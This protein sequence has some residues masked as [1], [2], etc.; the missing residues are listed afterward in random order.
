MSDVDPSIPLAVRP[1]QIDNPMDVQA[2]GLQLKQLALQTQSAQQDYNDSQTLRSLYQKNSAGGTLDQ[3]GLLNDAYSAGLGTKAL[4]IQQ[5]YLA[6]QK[7]QSDIGKNTADA[8]SANASAASSQFEVQQKKL[9]VIDQTL[10][11]LI[12][13]PNLNQ[14]HVI[15]ALNDLTNKGLLD[16]NQAA[17]MARQI[18]GDPQQLRPFLIQKGQETQSLQQQLATQAAMAPKIEYQDT[19]GAKV[20]VNTNPLSPGYAPPASIQKTVSP[21][22]QATIGNAMTV[23]K[24]EYGFGP[25]GKLSPASEALAQGLANGTIPWSAR[26]ES[27]KS[28]A[29]IERAKQLKPDLDI[30]VMQARSKAIDDY[31]NGVPAQ[32]LQSNGTAVKHL[33]LLS[34][35]VDNLKNTNSP[36]YNAAANAVATFTGG[37]VP[38]SFELAKTVAADEIMKSIVPGA[39]GEGERTALAD[40]I[41]ASSSPQQLKDVLGTAVGL[42]NGQKESLIQRGRAAGVPDSVFVDY[43]EGGANGRAPG[44]STVPSDIAAILAK[45]G[46]K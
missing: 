5:Q 2:K 9:G 42:M 33:G 8:N 20:A 1:V 15:G 28:D 41:R 46:G 23:A 10:S 19:G 11:S 12:N 24:M 36:T 22:T 21:D 18:P 25:D 30:P 32:Q 44:A 14:S 34:N 37:S 27:P 40:K 7:T 35:L 6:N 17:Q 29:I 31:T 45:H 13:T 26:L 38:T 39:G 3:H 16:P 43:T 4:A